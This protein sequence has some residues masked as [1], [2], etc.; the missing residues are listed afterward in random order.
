M[1]FQ[2]VRNTVEVV[3]KAQ[4]N[5]NRRENVIHYN[6]GGHI[7]TLTDLN[8]LAQELDN[9]LVLAQATVTCNQTTWFEITCRDLNQEGGLATSHT[10]AKAGII[11]ADPFPGNVSF[12]LTK[13]TGIAARWARGRYY[14]FDM[15]EDFFNGDL[16]NPIELPNLTVIAN[17]LMADHVNGVFTPAVASRKLGLSNIL[18]AITFDFNADSQRRRLAGRGI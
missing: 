7:L 18:T 13:R 3:L 10:M 11:A 14:L 15:V 8:N 5:G 6:Y 2:P 17:R 9:D 4:R 12:V 16:L 1:P